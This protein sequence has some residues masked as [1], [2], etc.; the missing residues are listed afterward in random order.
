MRSVRRASAGSGW[1]VLFL[2]VT[3]VNAVNNW[4]FPLPVSLEGG[5]PAAQTAEMAS[6][7]RWHHVC[8]PCSSWL[9]PTPRP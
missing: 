6:L 7:T 4:D 9:G 8:E 1:T 2:A 5:V 3:D